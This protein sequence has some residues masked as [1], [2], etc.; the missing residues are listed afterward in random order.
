MN[1]ERLHILYD[2]LMWGTLGH[3]K[4]D[5]STYNSTHE[6]T[7]GTAGCAIGECPVIWGEWRFNYEGKPRLGEN[8]SCSNS[9]AEWFGIN[10]AEYI[11]MFVPNSQNTDNFGGRSLKNFS[12][13]Y[14]VA[15]NIKAFINKCYKEEA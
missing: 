14:Q 11:H 13:R 12:N 10:H 8:C 2:H 7:C 4:F 6:P 15:A 5:F 9:G 3:K 1:L